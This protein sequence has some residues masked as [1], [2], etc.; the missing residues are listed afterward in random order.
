MLI[1]NLTV[2]SYNN[3]APQLLIQDASITTGSIVLDL[4]DSIVPG[5][6]NFDH[7]LPIKDAKVSL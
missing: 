7:L 1:I 2:L 4:V 6:V 5:S 3:Y